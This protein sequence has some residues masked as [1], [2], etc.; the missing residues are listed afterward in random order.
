MNV[1]CFLLSVLEKRVVHLSS[2][3]H[4]LFILPINSVS[5]L[6]WWMV[7][8]HLTTSFGHRW[9]IVFL[10]STR[11][12][13]S[14]SFIPT[15]SFLWERSEI[16]CSWN[17]PRLGTHAFKIDCLSRS[18]GKLN[19]MSFSARKIIRIEIWTPNDLCECYFSLPTFYSM[20]MVT[21][22]YLIWV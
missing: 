5:F 21:F 11:W 18:E 14:L 9:W 22:A 12:W 20:N 2:V 16:L 4:T 3:W 15:W 7:R 10:S 1:S 13:S 6:I 17:H 19:A 8:I